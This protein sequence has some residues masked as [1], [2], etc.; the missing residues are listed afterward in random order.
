SPTPQNDGAAPDRPAASDS[1]AGFGPRPAAAPAGTSLAQPTV[2][3]TVP[4][5]RSPVAVAA[6]AGGTA[7][8]AVEDAN[9]LL[10]VDGATDAVTAEVPLPATPQ[11]VTASPDGTRAFVSMS[12]GTGGQIAVV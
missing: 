10:V 11:G 8:V 4:A 7:L 5:G 3:A 2:R 6:T 12:D 9:R 1:G